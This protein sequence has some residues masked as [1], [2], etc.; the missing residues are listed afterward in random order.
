MRF[1]ALALLVSIACEAQPRIYDRTCDVSSRRSSRGGVYCASLAPFVL[2]NSYDFTGTPTSCAAALAANRVARCAPN[3][4]AT[5]WECVNNAGAS[6]ATVTQGTGTTYVGTYRAGANAINDVTTTTRPTATGAAFDALP[7]GDLTVVISGYS[8]DL[9]GTGI[10]SLMALLDGSFN[11]GMGIRLNAGQLECNWL[12]NGASFQSLSGGLNGRDGWAVSSCR[13]SGNNRITRVNG[14]DGATVSTAGTRAVPTGA[15]VNFG[16]SQTPGSPSRGPFAYFDFYNVGKSAAQMA[17]L[18]A[19]AW[20]VTPTTTAGIGQQL[21]ADNLDVSGFVDIMYPNSTIVHPT[22]GLQTVR[23]FTP[24]WAVD[25]LD[26]DSWTDVG[27][28]AVTANVARGPFSRWKNS[29]DVDRV[30]DNDAAAF[31]GL[32]STGSA[33]ADV[34][35]YTA[36]CYVAAGDTGTTRDKVRLRVVT[37]GAGSASCDFADLT[38]TYVRKTCPVLI[39]G[40]PSFVRGQVLVGTAAADTGSVLVAHCS[41]NPKT[42]AEV[43][44]TNND[45]VGNVQSLLIDPVAD[46]WP[47]PATGGKYEFVFTPTSSSGAPSWQTT[48][49]TTYVFD[50]VEAS[51][52]HAVTFIFGYQSAGNALALTSNSGGSTF[53]QTAGVTLVPYTPYVTSIE[54]RPVSGGKCDITQRLDV[55]AGGAAA[56]HATTALNTTLAGECPGIPTNLALGMRYTGAAFPTSAWFGAVR[57]YGL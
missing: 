1:A 43:P 50:A 26:A 39:S 11:D 44:T 29:A 55:C 51:T 17:V 37:D 3:A 2:S 13:R 54:W 6:V 36:A 46:G 16:T 34:G 40:T 22:R 27:T 45:M 5:A 21:G 24:S 12:E 28:P 32:E 52:N 15:V 30:V 4:G 48:D 10:Q 53:M 49:D 42:W 23:G 20:N 41:I 38:A 35:Y 31:E 7:G 25:P 18:E 19:C 47:D 8:T 14:A 33:G 9:S 57:I 56:C